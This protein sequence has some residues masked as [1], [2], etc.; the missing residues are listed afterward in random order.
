MRL[1]THAA[2][3]ELRKPQP[4]MQELNEI[5]DDLA[6]DEERASEVIDRLRALF[7]REALAREQV[8]I[9][10]CIETILALEHSDLTTR[11][12]AVDVTIDPALPPVIAAQAQ[13]Q[14]VLLNLISNACEAIAQS[15]AEG[16][17]H[18][19][20][21]SHA[22]EVRVAVSDNGS[23]VADF[24][25]IFEP[26]FST[27]QQKA[28]LGLTIARTIIVEHGGRLWGANNATGGAT[29]YMALPASYSS[30]MK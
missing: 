30:G 28:G 21:Q 9:A 7:P 16:R 5:L 14:Q 29:F 4:R 26:F 15:G 20:A 23:G 17:L 13:L 27:K 3:L 1:N 10:D 12:V 11:N 19:A 6:A 25:R 18:I 2:R 24:E 22:G 8:H